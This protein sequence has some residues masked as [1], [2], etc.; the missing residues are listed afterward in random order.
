M[1]TYVI[2]GTGGR[3]IMFTRALTSEFVASSKLLAICDKNKGR[4]QL[5]KKNLKKCCLEL[6]TYMD[7]DFDRMLSEQNPNCVIVCTMDSTHD[8]YICRSLEAG[9][10]VITEKP[11]TIDEKRCQRIVNTVKKTSKSVRVTF[12]YR[13]SPSRSQIKELLMSGVIGKILSVEFKW[14]LDTNHGV[15]YFRRWHRNKANSGGLMVHKATHHFD[16]VNW[17][18]SSTPETVFA[19]GDRLFYNEKQA[20]RYGLENHGDRC[21][22]CSVKDKCNFYLDM[23]K[24]ET[25]KKLYLDCEQYDGYIRDCC[26]FSNDIDIEDSID[27]IV[28]YKSSALLSYSLCAFSPWEGYKVEFNGTRGRLEHSCQESSY[29]NGDGCVQGAFDPESAITRIYLH[30]KTPYSVKVKEG[31]GGHGGGDIVMLNDIFGSPPKD[32]LMRSADYVQGAYSIL[33]GVAANKSIAS[34]RLINVKD[35]V[36]GLPDAKF[37]DMPGEEEYIPYVADAKRY[38]DGEKTDANVPLKL[39]NDS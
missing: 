37:P 26:V 10:D 33:V 31:Q 13:Y 27:V 20:R 32:P 2:V 19:K 22:N 38:I 9:C 17:W 8:D 11:M 34:G 15:D 28:G 7:N 3:S 6:A 21:L 25:I 18:L 12:N 36:S 30:F 14:L 23:N 5:T 16:L 39:Q 29:I 24:F 1:K 35:L 4:L